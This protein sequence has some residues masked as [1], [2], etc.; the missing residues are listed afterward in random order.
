MHFP[1]MDTAVSLTP[2]Q[3]LAASKELRAFTMIDFRVEETA[4]VFYLRHGDGSRVISYRR[5]ENVIP[6]HNSPQD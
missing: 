5:Q 4:F 3:I 2:D 6:T 1:E